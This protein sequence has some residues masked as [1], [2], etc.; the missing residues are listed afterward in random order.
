MR[1]KWGDHLHQRHD[2]AARHRAGIGL[3]Q[4]VDVLDELG[5]HGVVAQILVVLAHAGDGA[6]QGLG[7]LVRQLSVLDA[8]L[9]GLLVDHEA[10]QP[11]QEAVRADDILC[12]PGTRGV[13]RAHGHLIHAQGIGAE[14]AA[15][16]VRGNGVLERLAHLAVLLVDLF[17]LVEELTVALLHFSGGYVDAARIG[18]GVRLDVALVKQAAVGLARGDKTEVKQYLVPEP[19]VEQVQHRVLDAADVEV[20]AARV[21]LAA[22][23]RP[24]T[25]VVQR[26]ELLR[27]RRVDVAQLVPGRAG[28]LWHHVGVAVVGLLTLAEVEGDFHPVSR[29]GQWGSGYGISVVGVEGNRVIVFHLRQ[30]HRQ[31]VLRQGVRLAVLVVD[32]G[33]GLAPVPLAREEP[34]AQLVLD[35][36]LA[37]AV[38]NEPAYRRLNR[39]V[40]T[41]PVDVQAL[42]VR[43]VDV[44]RVTREGLRG[45]VRIQH[46]G[47]G[48]GEDLGELVVA[49]VVSGNRHD[50]A[51]AVAGEHVISDEHRHLL[52]VDRVGG[53]GTEE[54]ARLFLV[55]LALHIALRGDRPLVG[56]D[57][58]GGGGGP[59][60]PGGVGVVGVRV[61]G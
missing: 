52:A 47:N 20:H 58:L 55:L 56:G 25:L 38:G 8:Q 33:E 23:A 17:A 49:L 14:V 53:V 5:H 1:S 28:P 50:R 30:L 45:H 39:R 48:Q 21:I 51:G 16:L 59:V 40:L 36:L 18:V 42:L 34:V 15:D 13:Q 4:V 32:N 54:H 31:H 43:G 12:S 24:V 7:I 44:R 57:G 46:R 35:P 37:V 22:R 19:G 6:V 9:A 29:L 2:G 11:L 60:R 61:G 41:H 26:A 10:P 3:G 27:V